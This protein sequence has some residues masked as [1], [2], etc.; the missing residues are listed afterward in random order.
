VKGV[1]VVFLPGQTVASMWDGQIDSR[2]GWCITV[3]WLA[4]SIIDVYY[5]Y[6][7]VRRP[8]LILDFA[9]TF[10]LNHLTLT[11]YY[12]AAVPSSLF[13]W[14]VVISGTCLTTLLAEQ[15]CVKREML[16]G[17]GISSH[18]EDV[19]DGNLRVDGLVA[20]AMELEQ[21]RRD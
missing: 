8:R 19:T 1:N 10:M 16:E 5:L 20:D 9:L 18:T 15:L 21:L 12:S 7:F 4:A 17:L 3:A 6:I 14:V 2:R 13:F 11:T